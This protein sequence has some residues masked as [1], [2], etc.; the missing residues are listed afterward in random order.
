MTN[1]GRYFPVLAYWKHSIIDEGDFP[2]AF[3]IWH[4]EDEWHNRDSYCSFTTEKVWK[5]KGDPVRHIDLRKWAGALV[6]A[7][8]S[9]NTMAKMAGG[10]CDNLL[11][12]VYR[13]WDRT[14][15][16][17]V[18]PA[19]NTLMWEHPVT[20]QHVRLLSDW[21]V[22]FVGPVSK[23]L[24]C[25]DEGMGA[26]AQVD[27]V[28]AAL[29]DA[30]RWQFPL[31]D[32]N[33]LPVGT[34]P[35]AF[36]AKRRLSHHTGV[37]L[38]CEEG[39]V[40]NAVEGGRILGWERFTG[41]QDKSPWW[42]DTDCVLVEGASGVVCYGE[43]NVDQR[44]K[45]RLEMSNPAARVVRR[46]E[47]L[48]RVKAV[49]PEGRERPDIPGHSRSMLHVELYERG[50]AKASERWSLDEPRPSYLLDPTPWLMDTHGCPKER[51]D[52]PS[53]PESMRK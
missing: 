43:I 31:V 41:P 14:R 1:W 27:D 46:G 40:V 22:R 28:V 26:M 3:K 33:G 17:I 20:H 24:A 13:A 7:P 4:D 12:S 48:G 36:G 5:K 30:L 53:W 42:L 10:V 16:V 52:M 18:A 11:T 50:Q 29:K 19:M 35:G 21:D 15:P 23:E 45:D 39:T 34:H 37:D 8:L 47:M 38:Y 6:I 44:V 49:V 9:A 2:G 25:A 32:C 51:L